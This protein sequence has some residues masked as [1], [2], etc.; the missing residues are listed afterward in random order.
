[1]HS[2]GPKTFLGLLGKNCLMDG[3]CQMSYT[4]YLVNQN[5]IKFLSDRDYNLLTRRALMKAKLTASR[6]LFPGSPSVTEAEIIRLF[7]SA[8]FETFLQS[9]MNAFE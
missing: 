7:T 3:G 8:A 6:S 1:M 4:G 2:F 5:G 9:A